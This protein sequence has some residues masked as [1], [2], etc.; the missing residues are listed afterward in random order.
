MCLSS[1]SP[2]VHADAP[3]RFLTR[4]RSVLPLRRTGAKDSRG[5]A[6]GKR[7]R[8]MTSDAQRFEIVQVV[9]ARDRAVLTAT[10]N[11]VIDFHALRLLGGTPSA[12]RRAVFR[13]GCKHRSRRPFRCARA[14]RSAAILIAPL[15]RT[16]RQRPPMVGP[17]CRT[18]ALAAPGAPAR[19]H[20]RA[21][22]CAAVHRRTRQCAAGEQRRALGP[23]R[24][25]HDRAAPRPKRTNGWC[26]RS[27]LALPPRGPR[28][29]RDISPTAAACSRCR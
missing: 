14:A 13:R 7:Q 20:H 6:V 23:A 27:P 16:A 12:H 17:E 10:R 5:G 26:A 19:R 4:R 28:A 24:I 3:K 11:A 25:R 15:R 2:S 9:V 22:P 29:A 1:L 18:A 21:A 8:K